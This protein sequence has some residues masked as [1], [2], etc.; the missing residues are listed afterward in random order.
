MTTRAL[1]A[2]LLLAPRAAGACAF[3]FGQADG[4]NGALNGFWLAV[5]T[6][7]GVTMALIGGIGYA[8]WTVERDRAA[9]DA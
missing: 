3:C 8:I 7:I 6:L 2:A 9:R 5:M 4:K 1:A